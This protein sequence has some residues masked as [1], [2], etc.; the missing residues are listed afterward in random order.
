MCLVDRYHCKLKVSYFSIDNARV[1]CTKKS[2]FVKHEHARY[3]IERH[4]SNVRVIYT[5]KSK[6]VKNER[7]RYTF[8]RY[9]R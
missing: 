9:E 8:E 1:I 6:F 3:T 4:E 7:A 5:R 2:K